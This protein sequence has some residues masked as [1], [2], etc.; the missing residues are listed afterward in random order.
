MLFLENG[1]DGIFLKTTEWIGVMGKFR[2]VGLRPF[3]GANDDHVAFEL[4]LGVSI[5]EQIRWE[6]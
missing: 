6:K 3:F 1:L 4:G 2:E 5:K